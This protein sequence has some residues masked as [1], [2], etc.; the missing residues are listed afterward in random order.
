MN[1]L[2]RSLGVLFLSFVTL[3]GMAAH[4]ARAADNYAVSRTFQIG[5]EG[6]WDYATLDDAGKFLYL[7]RTTHTMVI[8]TGSGSVVA[9][10]PGA[11]GN[12]GVALVPSAGR[13]FITDGEKGV[14]QIFD[15]KTNAVLGSVP[16]NDDADG[17][18][19]DSTSNRVLVACGDAGQLVVIDPA[20]D[21][22]SGQPVAKIDLG[23][24]PEF[25]AADGEGHAFVNLTDKG[26]V[27]VVD[28]QTNKVTATWPVA[29]GANATGLSIDRE[30]GRLFI[31]C[32][33][34]H[35]IVMSTKDGAVLADLPIGPGVD[36]TV[37]NDGN[38]M[39]SCSDGTLVIVRETSPGKF[40]IVQ[41]VKTAAGAR[42][43]AIDHNTGAIYL[44]C[45]NMLPATRPGGRPT[46]APGTFKVVVVTK[47]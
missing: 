17:T 35:F 10:I 11:V 47:N 9:D 18:I 28:L 44:P 45:A 31:G 6:R 23:G 22:T 43:M 27:A 29:P 16:A 25:L 36:A 33:N 1:Q 15:L 39:A 14:V 32:R 8:D 38:G 20:V 46:A 12:H 3:V 40:E 5:G 21:P 19:Y 13:G 37:F 34:Q 2:S 4:R 30:N 42:T 7:T 24:K 41:T 26:Q